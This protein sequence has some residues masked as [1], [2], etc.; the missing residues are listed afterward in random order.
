M[1]SYVR[2]CFYL[3]FYSVCA[4]KLYTVCIA[5]WF[6]G[7]RIFANQLASKRGTDEDMDVDTEEDEF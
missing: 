1:R 4:V 2:K 6:V 5:M 3:Q 7:F